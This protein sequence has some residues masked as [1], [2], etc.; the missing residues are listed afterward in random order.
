MIP[1]L[2]GFAAL[3]R[4]EARRGSPQE[5]ERFAAGRSPAAIGGP[6]SVFQVF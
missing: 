3:L 5:T 1:P 4:H 6:Y 2:S